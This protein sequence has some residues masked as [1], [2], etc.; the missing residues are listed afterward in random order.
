MRFPLYPDSHIATDPSHPTQIYSAAGS[1]LIM[2]VLL[3]ARA[4]T[5][6]RGQLFLLYLMLYSVIRAGI[7]ALRSGYTAQVL[8][9]GITQG[10]MA[11]AVIFVAALFVYLS[12]GIRRASETETGEGGSSE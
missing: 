6:A 7:E 3:W 4:R 12:L 8:F 10:Q 5:P 9:D 1:F 2:A 11:S